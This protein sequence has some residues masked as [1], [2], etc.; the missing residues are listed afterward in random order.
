[1]SKK[2]GKTVEAPKQ[3]EQ[4]APTEPMTLQEGAELQTGRQLAHE[5]G[6]QVLVKE[7]SGIKAE[8]IHDRAAKVPIESKIPTTDE[9]L[10]SMVVTLQQQA[11]NLVG[12]INELGE[13]VAAT[14]EL[15]TQL[16]ARVSHLELIL[17]VTASSA[18]EGAG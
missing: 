2:K 5:L 3:E 14:A 1:M 15:N 7:G 8:D 6:S 17:G 11:A 10:T 12:K 18:A 13:V 16:A 4:A 9:V